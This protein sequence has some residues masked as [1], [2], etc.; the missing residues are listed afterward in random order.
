MIKNSITLLIGVTLSVMS[1]T[2]F[3][4]DIYFDHEA[5]NEPNSCGE[6]NNEIPLVS[7]T[8]GIDGVH[9]RNLRCVTDID[10]LRLKLHKAGL[11]RSAPDQNDPSTDWDEKCVFIINDDSGIN[12]TVTKGSVGA[13]SEDKIDLTNLVEGTYTHAVLMV[14]NSIDTK[15][16]AKFSENFRGLNS[17]GP[18]CY[19]IDAVSPDNQP[20]LSELAVKCVADEAAMIAAGDYDFSSKVFEGWPITRSTID[21]SKVATNGDILNLFSDM[22]TKAIATGNSS[23]ATK[24]VGVIEMDVPAVVSP[25]S[26][27]FVAGFQ[28]SDQGQIRFSGHGECRPSTLSSGSAL[29]S[30]TACVTTMRNYGVGF[31]VTVE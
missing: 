7:S 15:M 18:F 27:T 24:V 11:C 13:I 10:A 4:A 3:A 31:R 29:S 6:V 17:E 9:A 2:G 8:V 30:I 21:V 25:L 19:S 26:S 5:N 12:F 28:L 23:N 1:S 22:N 14:G 20:A 16:N